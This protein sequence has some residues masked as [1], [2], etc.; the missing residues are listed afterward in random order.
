MWT[1]YLPVSNTPHQLPHLRSLL[2]T[3]FGSNILCEL[4][5]YPFS[6]DVL[7]TCLVDHTPHSHANVDT[8]LLLPDRMALRLHFQEGNG[9]KGDRRKKRD[10]VLMS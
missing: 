10:P 3:D 6:T 8:H 4:C 9:K 5:L 7:L 1:F 2:V